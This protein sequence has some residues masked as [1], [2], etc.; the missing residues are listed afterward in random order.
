MARSAL[1]QDTMNH[2]SFSEEYYVID[3]GAKEVNARVFPSLNTPLPLVTAIWRNEC[4]GIDRSFLMQ[5]IINQ[6]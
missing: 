4:T 3:G 6:K 5:G 2:V 1:I